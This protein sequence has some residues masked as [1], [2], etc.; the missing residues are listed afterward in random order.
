LR[1]RKLIESSF[2]ELL[3]FENPD[4]AKYCSNCGASLSWPCMNCGYKLDWSPQSTQLPILERL[5]PGELAAK[6]AAASSGNPLNGER[7]VATILFCDIQGS[8]NASGQMDP[9]E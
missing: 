6:V 3:E 7:R 9:E 4:S 1:T 8:T 2:N 5:I